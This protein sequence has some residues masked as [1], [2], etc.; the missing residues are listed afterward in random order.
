MHVVIIQEQPHQRETPR[1]IVLGLGL[2]CSADDCVTFD[3]M[4][5]RLAQGQVDLVLVQVGRDVRLAQRAIQQA[6]PLTTAPVMAV[7]PTKDPQLIL[8]MV[9]AGA[10]RYLDERYL[11]EEL[12]HA[13]DQLLP[14][15]GA[16]G[17]PKGRLLAV[18]SAVPGIGVSTV[19]ANT[20]F[21]LAQTYPGRVALAELTSGVPSLSLT[22]DLA[23]RFLLSDVLQNWE[24]LDTT[25]LRQALCDHP[26][27]LAVL[28]HPAD[29]LSTP[30]LAAPA[31]RTL[32]LLLRSMFDDVVADLG[33]TLDAAT[34][35]AMKLAER[36]LVVTRLDV[37]A[38]RLTRK[39]VQQL[40]QRGLPAE[41]VHLIA[42]RF[43][44]GCQVAWKQAE[45]AVVLPIQDTIPDDAVA[46]NRAMNMGVPLVRAA[47]SA[48]IT[49]SF[50]A[51]AERLGRPV[52]A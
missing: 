32:V 25:M 2:V 42:N 20:A 9:R 10:R 35:E 27:G 14:T 37:P 29:T 5:L 18:T 49:R 44:Q 3:A 51:L 21:A 23:P 34:L 24:R 11:R 38:L 46:V 30:P 40:L 17:E 45:Q 36:V 12:Q 22:L 13:I 48:R 4:P 16:A 50:A 52:T 33:H 28:A 6:L 31:V 26:A 39:Y 15:L 19:A 43:G 8:R 7:G 1:Q 47:R 41:R